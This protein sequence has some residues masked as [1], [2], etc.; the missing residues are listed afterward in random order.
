MEKNNIFLKASSILM[1]IGG[2]FGLL[3]GIV[4]L[5]FGVLLGIAA[6]HNPG[7]GVTQVVGLV[8]AGVV[9]ALVGT[10]IQFIAGIVGSKN[11]NNPEKAKLCIILGIINAVLVLTSLIFDYIGGGIHNF[12][13][14]FLV[15]FGLIV[16]TLYLVGAFQL[17]SKD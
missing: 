4:I 1:I 7:P 10:L 2:S 9:L 15:L 8:E 11:A 6:I 12:Y 16:P 3:F 17:K 14:V 5:L 13:N